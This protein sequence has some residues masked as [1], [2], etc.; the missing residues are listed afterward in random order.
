MGAEPSKKGGDKA[1]RA[2][3]AKDRLEPRSSDAARWFKGNLL[4]D[5]VPDLLPGAGRHQGAAGR[6]GRPVSIGTPRQSACTPNTPLCDVAPSGF[7]GEALPSLHTLR[8]RHALDGSRLAPLIAQD[9]VLELGTTRASLGTSSRLGRP[10]YTSNL[11]GC[12]ALE[13]A[14]RNRCPFLVRQSRECVASGS[15]LLLLGDAFNRAREI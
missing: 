15:A 5:F 12:Q 6:H 8:V 3:G 10:P 4:K 2:R 1:R 7:G 14:K 13:N 11:A 9:A